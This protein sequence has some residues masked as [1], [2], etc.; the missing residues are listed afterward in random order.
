MK[1]II[2]TT[3]LLIFIYSLKSQDLSFLPYN[4]KP[5]QKLTPKEDE[6]YKPLGAVILYENRIM[7]CIYNKN[8]VLM[9]YDIFHRTIKVYNRKEID[10]NNRIYIKNRENEDIIDIKARFI[11]KEG[12]ITEVDKSSIKT[13]DNLESDGNYKIFAIEGAEPDGVIDYFYVI[14]K[15]PSFYGG[16]YLQTNYPKL[17]LNMTIVLPQNLRM[18]TKSYNGLPEMKDSLIEKEQK[19][20]YT[21]KNVYIPELE[22]EKF[23]AYKA[24]LQRIEYV[25]CY[26]YAVNK[27]RFYTF[28]EAAQKFYENVFSIE[29]DEKKAV[30]KILNEI[31]IPSKLSTEEKIRKI[32]LYVK[33]H[34]SYIEN[35]SPNFNKLDQVYEN[36]QANSTGFTRLFANLFRESEIEVEPLLTCNKNDCELDKNF[37]AWNNLNDNLL[38]FPEINKYMIPDHWAYRLGLIPSDFI[39]NNGLFFKLTKVGDVES[40]IPEVRRIPVQPY[41]ENADSLFLDVKLTD[42]CTNTYS[43]LRRVLTGYTGYSIQPFIK[44]MKKE[45]KDE[46]LNHYG[47]LKLENAVTKDLQFFNTEPEDFYVKPFVIKSSFDYQGFVEKAGNNILI[48]VGEMIGPQSELYDDN[49]PRKTEVVNRYN[50]HYYRKIQIEIPSGYKVA[51]L[52][53]INM[54]VNS[55]DRSTPTSAFISKAEVTNN[56]LVV[57]IIEYYSQLRY[58]ADKYENFRRVVNAAADFNKKTIMLTKM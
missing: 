47:R 6:K 4:F 56:K 10:E 29:K 46:I 9:S 8:N 28:N 53:S 44:I 24:S 18:L 27:T 22:E 1:K 7:S 30:K 41:Q 21:L 57:E 40:F 20:V 55:N 54:N 42:E 3:I 19:R 38:Y 23:S 39:D 58:P 49:K 45:S 35:S 33:T 52:E 5:I 43:K 34:F 51:N 25:I 37:D 11:S 48:K 32:E 14:K 2:F 15:R 16:Y 50:R 12:K 17:D 26:N 13:V 36:K 31:K